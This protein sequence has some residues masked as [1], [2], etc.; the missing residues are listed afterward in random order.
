M[1]PTDDMSLAPFSL[2]SVS[3]SNLKLCPEFSEKKS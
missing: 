3:D 2:C 1:T